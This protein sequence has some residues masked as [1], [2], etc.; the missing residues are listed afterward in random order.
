MKE[1]QTHTHNITQHAMRRYVNVHNIIDERLTERE[2]CER[3]KNDAIIG[4]L[5]AIHLYTFVCT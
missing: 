1:L 5:F 4:A 2:D 3:N